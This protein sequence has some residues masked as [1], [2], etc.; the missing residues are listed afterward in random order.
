MGVRRPAARAPC[1]RVRRRRAARLCFAVRGLRF[2]LNL[3]P[4][5]PAPIKATLVGWCFGALWFLALPAALVLVV[6]TW[7]DSAGAWAGELAEVVRDH[8]VPVAILVF[9]L[10]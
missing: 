5:P 8:R 4:S 9:T 7:S 2:L 3:V 10:A 1:G 6:V